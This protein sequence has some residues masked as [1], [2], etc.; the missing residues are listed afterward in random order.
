MSAL[1]EVE[2]L[3]KKFGGL[4]ALSDVSFSVPAGAIV[5]VMGANGAG[6]TTLFSLIAGNARPSNGDIRFDGRSIVGLSPD[7][8]CRLG[9]AR[10]FQIVKPFPAMTVRENLR[11]AAMFGHAQQRTREAADAAT[12]SVLEEVGLVAD[13]ERPASALTLSG[14]KRLEIAR[15]VATGGRL[16]MLDEVMAGLTPTEVAQMLQTVRQLQA[17]RG[18]TLLVIEHV[19]RALMELCEHIV[20]L[21]HGQL[22]AEG[23]PEQIGRDA[24]VHAVYFG[25]AH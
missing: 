14:Q 1:L 12:Q 19:M 5:G 21:H 4:T 15:A 13:A 16:V 23:T 18:L 11:T 17:G 10:T 6:K 2:S 20:V 7:R 24:Q 9:V 3:S 22:I 25:G 8:V